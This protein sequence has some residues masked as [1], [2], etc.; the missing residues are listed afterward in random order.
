MKDPNEPLS[1]PSEK[2]IVVTQSWG[3]Y[4][5]IIGV[6]YGLILLIGWKEFTSNWTTFLIFVYCALQVILPTFLAFKYLAMRK[7]IMTPSGVVIEVGDKREEI[8][9]KKETLQKIKVSYVSGFILGKRGKDPKVVFQFYLKPEHVH[10]FRGFKKMLYAKKLSVSNYVLQE[11]SVEVLE[12]LRR[13]YGDVEC[14][15]DPAVREYLERKYGGDQAL[16][17]PS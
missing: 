6:L 13:F 11:K 16:S 14:S 2:A 12:F 4:W 15:I 7:L 9:Y 10:P 17:L 5:L 8:L 1:V 3:D